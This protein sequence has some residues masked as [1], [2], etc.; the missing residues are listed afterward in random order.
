MPPVR[1]GRPSSAGVRSAATVL[2]GLQEE[3]ARQVAGELAVD[4]Q[5]GLGVGQQPADDGNHPPVAGELAE[6]LAARPGDAEGEVWRA[7][8]DAPPGATTTAA[9]SRPS[10]QLVVPVWQAAP[11]WST[12]TS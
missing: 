1:G 2:G 4:P 5:R 3:R 12:P 7:A 8:H 11:T 9:S 6:L 10:K